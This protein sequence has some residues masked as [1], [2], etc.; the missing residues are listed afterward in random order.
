MLSDTTAPTVS[1][2]SV[3]GTSLEIVFDKTLAAAASLV[4]S[5]FTVEKTPQGGT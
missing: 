5:A 3:D 1:S 4:N 2:A